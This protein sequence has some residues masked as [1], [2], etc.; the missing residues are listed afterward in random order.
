[1]DGAPQAVSWRGKAI[2]DMTRD[3]LITALNEAAL[4]ILAGHQ[5]QQE[6]LNSWGRCIAARRQSGRR[7]L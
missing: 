5:A 4:M 6:T 7:G 2:N 3:E 1:M